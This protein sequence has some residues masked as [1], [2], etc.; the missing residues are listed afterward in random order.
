MQ[1]Y[2]VEGYELVKFYGEATK[3]SQVFSDIEQDLKSQNRVVCQY[4][5]NGRDVAEEDEIT[6]SDLALSEVKSLE[7]LSE[8]VGRL[9]EDVVETWIKAL[10]EFVEQIDVLSQEL[11]FDLKARTKKS[12]V[13]MIE[14]CEFL[15]D[16]LIPIKSLLGDS[17][18]VGLDSM[19][20]AEQQTR[21]ALTEAI[22][23]LEKKDFVLLADIIEY[24]LTVALQGWHK[25]L[26]E[27]LPV[28]QN[29]TRDSKDNDT[30]D[31][32]RMGEKRFEFDN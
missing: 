15:V 2:K 4:I 28:V 18:A 17:I 8:G 25:G 7:Y 13:A 19:V 11:R 1:R 32:P 20:T 26:V 6:F 30:K 3:L 24:E 16:S 14:N 9:V 29:S 21:K 5:V 27:L 22:T 31:A 23:A 12:I 10:P